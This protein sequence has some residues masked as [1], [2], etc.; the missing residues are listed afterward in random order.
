MKKMNDW[1]PGCTLETLQAR[2][3]LIRA[4]RGFFEARG[5]LEVD[6]PVLSECATVDPNIESFSASPRHWLQTSP[7]F[8]MKRLVTAGSGPIFQIARVFRREEAGTYHNPEFS[9][10]EWYRPGWEYRQLMAE[11][12]ELVS[13]LG[14]ETGRGV[15]TLSYRDAFLQFAGVDPFLATTD[16]LESRCREC[17]AS[18][19]QAPQRGDAERRDFLLDLL[20][21][22]VVSPALGTKTPVFLC[23]F[24]A[25]Q[26][27]L[28]RIRTD[29]PPVAERFEMFWRGIELANGFS[30]LTGAGEQQRRFEQDQALRQARGQDVPPFDSRLIA[31]LAAG[32]PASAGVAL[33]VDRLLMML[34]DLGSIAEA[35]PFDARRA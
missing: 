15:E 31:A 26:A 33:G 22:A 2:S 21:S 32:M 34:L 30:E 23:D 9:M 20:M 17:Y 8:A 12:A 3:R 24:P 11:T 13:Q 5:V 6:T 25:S 28:A 29:V 10:L 7:E 14:V 4:I 27:A 1:S 18:M 16:R 19:P 35:M